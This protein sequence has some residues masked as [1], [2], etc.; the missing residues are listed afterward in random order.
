MKLNRVA[1]RES[2][3][4]T[5]AAAAVVLSALLFAASAQA[6]DGMMYEVK[7][8]NVTKAQSFTPIIIATDRNRIRFFELGEPASD[9]LATMAE[10]GNTDLL[11]ESFLEK[12]AAVY[13]DDGGLLGPGETRVFSIEVGSR[14]RYLSLSGMLLPTNDTF[15]ALNSV[16]LPRHRQTTY[17][18]LGYD[19][20]TEQNDQDCASIPGPL[21]GGEPDS[22]AAETDEGYVYVSNGFQDLGEEVLGPVMYDWRNPIA[23]INIKP[24]R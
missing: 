3:A 12:G 20:G 8:T 1:A 17:T 4:R 7:I 16:K 11:A 18:A 9:A 15:V 24:I 10:A 21:C 22:A 14:D 6:N 13:Q 2:L 19:A 23:Q 5:A